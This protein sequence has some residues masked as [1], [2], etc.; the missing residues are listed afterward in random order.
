MLLMMTLFEAVVYTLVE[1]FHPPTR[2]AHPSVNCAC[3]FLAM[4]SQTVTERFS[5][6][7]G[8]CGCFLGSRCG[9]SGSSV[10]TAVL[11]VRDRIAGRI[12]SCARFDREGCRRG[13]GNGF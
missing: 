11:S 5:R 2:L 4:D 7:M 3:E 12:A 1:W 9:S 13:I 6:L 10:E 8:D